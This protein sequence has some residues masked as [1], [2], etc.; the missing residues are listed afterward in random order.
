MEIFVDGSAVSKMKGQKPVFTRHGWAVVTE[1]T[2][3]AGKSPCQHENGQSSAVAVAEAIA[4][5][6]A[7]AM[8]KP[9]DVIFTDQEPMV[10]ALENFGSVSGFNNEKAHERRM[11]TSHG[12]KLYSIKQTIDALLRTR[13]GVTI[14]HLPREHSTLLMSRKRD[15]TGA[16]LAD[17]ISRRAATAKHRNDWM[18]NIEQNENLFHALMGKKIVA[19]SLLNG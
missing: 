2:V 11:S 12:R 8:S 14:A 13:Q 10:Q 7:V 15:T 3:Y 17:Q 6:K 9:G 18:L 19:S 16:Y 1:D 5:L 4:L